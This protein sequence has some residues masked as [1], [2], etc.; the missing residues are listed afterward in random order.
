MRLLTASG[1]IDLAFA[2]PPADLHLG[3]QAVRRV[4]ERALH[5]AI[6]RNE[7]GKAGGY[8]T[9]LSDNRVMGRRIVIYS[10]V[11]PLTPEEAAR[12]PWVREGGMSGA[13]M[14]NRVEH[15]LNAPC[16][17]ASREHPAVEVIAGAI[18]AAVGACQV[19]VA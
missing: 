4:C 12:E 2:W 6:M 9:L 17:E 7:P 18:E 13:P 15:G 5:V 11:E 1:P 14:V 19:R 8:E 3:R 16:I 10:V